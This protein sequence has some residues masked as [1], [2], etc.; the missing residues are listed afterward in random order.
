MNNKL[1]QNKT[2]EGSNAP[3]VPDLRV[4]TP[5]ELVPIEGA[6]RVIEIKTGLIGA[7]FFAK[8]GSVYTGGWSTERKAF[9]AARA[10]LRKR[11]PDATFKQILN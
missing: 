5:E 1:E 2:G 7:G 4:P 10:M 6:P 11:N 3:R 9:N 8:S